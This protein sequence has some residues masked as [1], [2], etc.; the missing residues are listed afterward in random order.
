MMDPNPSTQLTQDAG[1][2]SKIFN[3]GEALQI[4]SYTHRTPPVYPIDGAKSIGEDSKLNEILAQTFIR[5]DELK[6]RS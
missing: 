4:C 2:S 5:E 6:E 1:H 3:K